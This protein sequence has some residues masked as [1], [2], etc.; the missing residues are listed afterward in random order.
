[1]IL[2][3]GVKWYKNRSSMLTGFTVWRDNFI[4][5]YQFPSLCECL[6]I[7]CSLDGSHGSKSSCNSGDLDSISGLGRSPEKGVVTHSSILAW[8]IPWTEESGWLQIMGHKELDMT[9]RL[10][11]SRQPSRSSYF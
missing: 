3:F 9:E 2:N 8:R 7:Q 11:T 6:V 5:K 1:M 4:I 10:T